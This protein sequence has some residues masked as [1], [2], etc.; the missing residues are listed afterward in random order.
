MVI[1]ASRRHGPGE[2]TPTLRHGREVL[3]FLR[4]SILLGPYFMPHPNLIDLPPP[5][6]AEKNVLSLLHLSSEILGPKA[7][8]KYQK[9]II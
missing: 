6:S 1:L 5:L 3:W 8:K 2:G 4:L 9:Y 7:D